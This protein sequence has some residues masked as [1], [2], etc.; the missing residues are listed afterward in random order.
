MPVLFT[1]SDQKHPRFVK[2]LTH[3]IHQVHTSLDIDVNR[4]PRILPCHTHGTLCRQ[5]KNVIRTHLVQ[6]RNNLILIQ[7]IQ[8]V[9]FH[10]GYLQLF[11]RQFCRMD[12]H[13]MIIL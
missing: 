5:M 13:S 8:V 10:P 12:F 7:N 1:G 4:K 11:M 3:R 9:D 6:Q 2:K